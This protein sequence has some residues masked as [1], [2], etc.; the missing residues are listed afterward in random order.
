MLGLVSLFFFFFGGGWCLLCGVGIGQKGMKQRINT[1]AAQHQ[2]Q[3]QDKD[4]GV[5]VGVQT[6]IPPDGS[7]SKT[8][9]EKPNAYHLDIMKQEERIITKKL[10]FVLH[11]I[12]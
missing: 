9:L 4:C 2:L 8:K 1:T 6:E 10:L 7:N 12:Y 5:S 3:E 11:D